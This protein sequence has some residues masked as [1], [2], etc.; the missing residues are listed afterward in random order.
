MKSRI[1]LVED[2][3][4]VALAVSDLLRAEDH[5]VETASDGKGGLRKAME[6]LELPVASGV[7]IR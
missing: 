6:E 3:F 7:G 5:S 4:D 2:E 1:L